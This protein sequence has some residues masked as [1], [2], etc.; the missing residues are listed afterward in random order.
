MSLF[1][2]DGL[3]SA[4]RLAPHGRGARDGAMRSDGQPMRWF[5]VLTIGLTVWIGCGRTELDLA[6]GG[7]I[8]VTTGSPNETTTPGQSG[9]AGSPGS[10]AAGEGA[11]RPPAI[12]GAA[13]SPAPTPIPCGNGACT[14]GKQICCLS[15]SGRRRQE[16]CIDAGATC[17]QD[18]VSLACV[19]GSSCATGTVCCETLLVPA[20]M[21]LAPDACSR[22]PGVI[23]CRGDTDCP[24]LAPHCCQTEDASVCS[25]QAC[26]AGSGFGGGNTGPGETN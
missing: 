24:V 3:G 14:A 2:S 21:C 4:R 25:A 13:G 10:S 5:V 12:A 22:S 23:I 17:P 26:P 15:G 20:T 19:D 9:G 7:T 11:G 8:P 16:T 6:G 1:V 18:A